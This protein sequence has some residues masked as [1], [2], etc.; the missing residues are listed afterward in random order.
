VIV[1]GYGTVVIS[2][3]GVSIAEFAH[4]SPPGQVAAVASVQTALAFSGAVIGPP[5]F[6]LIA[7]VAGYPPAFLAVAVCVLA[8]AFWQIATARSAFSPSRVR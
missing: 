3:N 6:G 7:A 2:W 8:V 4:L 5:A 1:F